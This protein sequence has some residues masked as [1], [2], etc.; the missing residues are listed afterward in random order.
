MA[1][2]V[3]ATQVMQ[4]ELLACTVT[5]KNFEEV[6]SMMVTNTDL[7]LQLAKANTQNSMV[8]AEKDIAM[9][10]MASTE[11]ELNQLCA[12]VDQAAMLLR[13]TD[14]VTSQARITELEEAL[15][16]SLALLKTSD[17]TIESQQEHLLRLEKLNRELNSGKQ[18]LVSKVGQL[19]CMIYPW[20]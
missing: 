6:H 20:R 12:K 11:S 16:Q 3:K 2:I 1:T 17:V 14:A 19:L 13:A 15:A 4:V 18:A 10:R 5:K 9:E 8:Q 7:H